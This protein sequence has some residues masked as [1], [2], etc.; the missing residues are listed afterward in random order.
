MVGSKPWTTDINRDP[1]LMHLLSLPAY[2]DPQDF[3]MPPA[4]AQ[5]FPTQALYSGPSL[6]GWLRSCTD[7]LGSS[8]LSALLPG[9]GASLV[10][11]L[12]GTRTSS[13]V[14]LDYF[15]LDLQTDLRACSCPV[16]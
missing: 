10:G 1:P 16:P 4:W 11:S 13:S 3:W 14:H 5:L 12:L 15:C 2:K 8:P 6:V 9:T 7:L